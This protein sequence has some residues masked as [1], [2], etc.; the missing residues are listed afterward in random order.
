MDGSLRV[1]R[2][3]E[4]DWALLRDVRLT[5]LAESPLA[6]AS[7]HAREAGFDEQMWRSRTRT[8]AWFIALGADGTP[9]GILAGRD[10]DDTPDGER[11][12]V[13]MWAAPA[14]RGTGVGAGLLEAVTAWARDD[15]ARTLTLWV[16]DGNDAA[17]RLYEGWG[18][19]STGERQPVPGRISAMEEKYALVLVH[20]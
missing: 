2:L 11:H 19:V 10:E 15:G 13:A 14:A 12:V 4:D 7:T 5:A 8:A 9:V 3:G 20:R 1:R 16:V 17:R 18:F 6:F